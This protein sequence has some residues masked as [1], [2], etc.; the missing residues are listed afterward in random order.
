MTIAAFMGL[1]IYG[2]DFAPEIPPAMDWFM[3]ISF[4][5]DGLVG[6]ILTLFGYGREVLHCNDMYC[7]FSDPRVLLKFLN[8]EKV[9]V[10]HQFGYLFVLL[11]VSR[12]AL[13]LSLRRRCRT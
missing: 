4:M 8:L 11:V 12:I 2:F 9:T 3:R 10:L 7:H 1:A 13:Y 5:R 6:F